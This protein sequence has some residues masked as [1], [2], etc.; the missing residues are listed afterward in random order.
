MQYLK[1]VAES[2]GWNFSH[3]NLT[4][5]PFKKSVVY[6]LMHANVQNVAAYQSYANITLNVAI[7][8]RVNFLKTE[9]DGLS[10]TTLYG[11]YGYTENQNYAHILQELYARFLV[12][13]YTL[14]VAE[15][16]IITYNYPLTG[17][18]FV[19]ESEDVVAGWSF[20]LTL[21]VHSPFVTDGRC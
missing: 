21:S 6:P 15:Y 3:G 11:E 12:K 13:L 4:E 17:S 18:P 19:E 9:N 10:L 7:I 20:T 16:D 1:E 2:C 8:D 14:N 5:R